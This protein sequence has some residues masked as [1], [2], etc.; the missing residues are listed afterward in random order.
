MKKIIENYK[1]PD[2]LVTSSLICQPKINFPAV[3][4]SGQ[5]ASE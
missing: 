2:S 1:V 4:I 5:I 3:P